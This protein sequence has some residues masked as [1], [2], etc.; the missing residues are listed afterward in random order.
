MDLSHLIPNN[1]QFFTGGLFLG[2][3]GGAAALIRAPLM[4]LWSRLINMCFVGVEVLNSDALYDDLQSWLGEI[5]SASRFRQLSAYVNGTYRNSNG[6]SSLQIPPD[7]DKRKRNIK[8]SA[9]PGTHFVVFE[10]TFIWVTR[11]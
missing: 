2:I 10:Q 1:N 9:S 4:S 5:P 6:M 11:L 3:M 8:F 7:K